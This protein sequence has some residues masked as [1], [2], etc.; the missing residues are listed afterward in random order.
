M[1]C[2]VN[3]AES[4][5]LLTQLSQAGYELSQPEGAD[6]VVLNTCSVTARADKEV[7]SLLRRLRRRN[8][9]AWLVATGCLAYLSPAALVGPELADQA[10]KLGEGANLA[11]WLPRF[12]NKTALELTPEPLSRATPEA[13]LNDSL[14]DQSALNNSPVNDELG[15]D[16]LGMA[17][18]ASFLPGRTR[19]FLKVQDGC[20]ANC[21]YCVVPLARGPARSLGLPV[22]RERL[23]TLWASGA[24]EVVLTGVHLGHYGRDLGLTL[25]DL[26]AALAETVPQTPNGDQWRGRLRLSSLEPLEIDQAY[27]ALGGGW[28][29]PHIHA[30]LQSGSDP[31]L[32]RMGRPYSRAD[33]QRAIWGLVDKFGPL[34]LGTDV[35]VGFPGETE[36]EFRE[37]R[38]LLASLP[39]SYWHVFPYSPRPGTRAATWPDQ[40]PGQVKKERVQLLKELGEKKRAQFLL[41]QYPLRHLALVENTLDAQG[42][43]RVLTGTYLRAVWA[44]SSQPAPNSLIWV[45]LSPPPPGGDNLPLAKPWSS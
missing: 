28:L 45:S 11:Q 15:N 25:T 30:P 34:A 22:V 32:R 17:G 37:T 12:P 14:A 31:V 38:D 27:P 9:R 7:F 43:R 16:E 40:V 41:T 4:A 8:P 33:Y 2:K 35:L 19:A 36:G 26:L 18:L 13:S 42:R 6:V 23:R 29:A 21:A 1:G 24:R 5:S 3:Q 10:L 20:S 39:L 44:D